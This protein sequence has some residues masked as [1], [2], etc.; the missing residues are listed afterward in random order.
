MLPSITC[1]PWVLSVQSHVVHGH[2]GNK[3]A[4]FP[5]QVL[6]FEVDAVNT[7]QF[8]N[9]TGY[10]GGFRGTRL[11]GE[12]LKDLME[13]LRI[14][15]LPAGRNGG[16]YSH[17]LVGYIGSAS[18]VR[19]LLSEVAWLKERNPGIRCV[20]DP[21]MGDH[22]RLYV[23][24]EVAD[25]ISK[26]L[27]PH[28][29]MLTPNQF[30]LETLTGIKLD[31]YATARLACEMLHA[32]G[33]ETVVVSSL[34][35]E[36]L[37]GRQRDSIHLYASQRVEGGLLT[38]RQ[39]IVDQPMVDGVYVG[40][41][42]LLAALLLA[43]EEKHPNDL[44]SALEVACSTMQAV[45]R[46][47]LRERGP[48]GEL[49]LVG[50]KLDIESPSV[51]VICSRLWSEADSV[52]APQPE[53][54]FVLTKDRPPIRGIIFDMDGTLTECKI[55]F[56]GLRETLGVPVGA[57][58]ITWVNNN[59]TGQARAEAETII[60]EFESRGMDAV[61]LQAGIDELLDAC[62][63]R[64]VRTAI[65][66]RNS[67]ASVDAILKRLRNNHFDPIV[68]RDY[69][70]RKPDPRVALTICSGWGLA[71]DEVLFVGN[72]ED[73]ILTGRGAGCQTCLVGDMNHHREPGKGRNR[74][75][76]A[77]H[78]VRILA[79]LLSRVLCSST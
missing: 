67:K 4:V 34:E 27:I 32:R 31:G 50:S 75:G 22:G 46:R 40:T 59:M 25:L 9:H 61:E 53:S 37:P 55:D 3:S 38:S 2:V 72:S 20:I 14:N 15:E 30:E 12:Q 70:F 13:G 26:E 57:D 43:A 74:T 1:R 54:C 39:Y 28:A 76:F 7:V 62:R 56:R 63:S 48:G 19:E 33:V 11:E 64:G 29:G 73:D 41:G 21:V 23:S 8:S 51:D 77:D 24:K 36:S 49:S 17:L 79:D 45:L 66:T 60:Q 58:I 5:L 65:A 78:T 18:C 6:G 35:P 71:P 10:K 42:D 47:T 69:E 52:S 16:G 68:T 44:P